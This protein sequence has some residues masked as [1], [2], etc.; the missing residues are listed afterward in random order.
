M[1]FF[2][3]KAA[4]LSDDSKLPHYNS[5]LPVLRVFSNFFFHRR[6]TYFFWAKSRFA[7]WW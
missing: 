7:E 3:L 6:Y 1:H 5:L 4:L 2:E